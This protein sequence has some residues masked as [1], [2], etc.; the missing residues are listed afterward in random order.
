[1]DNASKFTSNEILVSECF[2]PHRTIMDASLHRAVEDY[3]NLNGIR[4]L[5]EFD[6]YLWP[7]I[8]S[9]RNIFAMSYLNGAVFAN[10]DPATSKTCGS[11]IKFN[12]FSYIFP[13]MNALLN[14]I[15]FDCFEM[16][17]NKNV[18]VAK[19]YFRDSVAKSQNG[20]I[21]LIVCASCQ[22]GQQIIEI[23]QTICEIK[24]R[25][26]SHYRLRALMVQGMPNFF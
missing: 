5:N 4:Q 24:S 3:L 21:L 1:M 14:K 15:E 17:Q 16:K 12:S 19:G 25:I 20:P 23:I 7:A 6:W 2:P 10:G 13:L 9:K 11:Q 22:R 26:G 8:S 18:N